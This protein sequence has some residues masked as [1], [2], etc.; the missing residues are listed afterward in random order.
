[1]CVPVPN[2]GT[3]CTVVSG[4]SLPSQDLFL[5]PHLGF[6]AWQDQTDTFVKDISQGNLMGQ[7]LSSDH[8]LFFHVHLDPIFELDKRTLSQF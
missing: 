3:P 4:Q 7:S 5:H 8:K 2:S 6:V 1:M